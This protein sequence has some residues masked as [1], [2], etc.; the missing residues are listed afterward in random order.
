M[1]NIFGTHFE[2]VILNITYHVDTCIFPMWFALIFIWASF[3]IPS[4]RDRALTHWIIS[5]LFV[6]SNIVNL[7]LCSVLKMIL[8]TNYLNVIVTFTVP[9][10]TILTSMFIL[11]PPS[12]RA[13]SIAYWLKWWMV[14]INLLILIF[15][16]VASKK[17][18]P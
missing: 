4:L 8:V 17:R 6:I 14:P 11:T 18:A 16:I 10:I 7:S 15:I 1:I 2:I 5:I 3:L 9:A 12:H 13:L